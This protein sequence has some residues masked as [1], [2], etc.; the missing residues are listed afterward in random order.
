MTAGLAQPTTSTPARV[1]ELFERVVDL[2]PHECEAVLRDS[3]LDASD[4]RRLRSLLEA[5][6][7]GGNLFDIP[8]AD[9]VKKLEDDSADLAGMVGQRAGPYRIVKMLGKGGS[10]V[11]FRAVRALGDSEQT[12]ALKLLHNG[13]F[14]PESRRRFRREQTILTQL[15]HPNIARLID[16]GISESGVPYIAM[17]EID[18]VDLITYADQHELGSAERLQLLI[19]VCRAVDAAHRT[20]VVHRDLK[21]SNV[22]VTN[23][24]HVK[25]LD[26]G[27]AKLL[28]DDE[29]ATATQHV[30]LTPGYAAPEQYGRG[31]VKTATDVYALGV[32]AGELFL[33]IRLGPDV[34]WPPMAE[35]ERVAI[36]R[37]WRKLDPEFV[38]LLRATLASE[39]DRRYASAG[40]LADDIERY[41]RFEP[42]AVRPVS[43]WYRLRKLVARNRASAAIATALLFAVL[44]GLAVTGWQTTKVRAQAA[45]ATAARDFLVSVFEAAGADLPRDKR[46]SVQDVVEQASQRLA[47]DSSLPDELH[48]DLLLTLAKVA[49]SVGSYDRALR[50]LDQA[51]PIVARLY[52][53]HDVAWIQARIL[54]AS[55]LTGSSRKEDAIALLDPLRTEFLDR[56]DRTGIEGLLYLAEVGLAEHGID[57]SMMLLRHAE[58]VAAA[59]RLA[60]LQLS[61]VIQQAHLLLNAEKFRDALERSDAAFAVWHGQGE[62]AL[63]TLIDLQSS[64]ALAA[65]AAGDIPRAEAAYR[66]AIALGDRFFDKPSPTTAWNVGMY[67]SFLIA[68]GRFDEAEPYAR[69]G[70]ELRRVVFGEADAHTLYA[71]AAM[72]KLYYGK[73]DFDQ[74]EQWLTQGV[75]TCVANAVHDEVCPRLL[76]LRGRAFARQNRFDQ[77]EGDVRAALE[78]QREIS[79]DSV[80]AY[81]F[82][83]DNLL[84]IQL[85]RRDFAKAVATADRILEIRASAR[86]GMLQADFATRFNRAK[87]LFELERNDEA[88]AE[89]ADIEPKY[90]TLFPDSGQRFEM[91]LYK[92]RAL[93]RANRANEAAD[94]ARESL[95][96]ARHKTGTNA[97]Q[98]DE[99]SALAT[100]SAR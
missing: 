60:D 55:V 53:P 68:Q 47:I 99:M 34:T 19:E 33:G 48:A 28:D 72:A 86:G 20:L 56:N 11:V 78:Q 46:P 24:G 61:A 50:L 79:G 32:L 87:A 18:G 88:L 90:S 100:A 36:S 93:A 76:A 73:N 2:A 98:V 81:A 58:A 15:S 94:A 84:T 54:R 41:L 82:I 62:P 16:G 45:R 91:L 70:L 66:E 63:P 97:A 52:G 96:L 80:P 5:D 67:G 12:V 3:G 44:T 49:R 40:H 23:D 85:A 6:R 21:P 64:V 10:A 92:A 57:D 77:A 22:L 89:F 75:E 38:D 25:V 29:P 31:P 39:P 65:E 37:R 26:F 43:H 59:Q 69:R 71:V 27:I 42:L 30:V 9:W 35:A 1:R 95:E 74:A 7:S 13:L 4:L 17:E 14:S 51:D 83:L 8:A